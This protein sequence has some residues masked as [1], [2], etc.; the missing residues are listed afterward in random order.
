MFRELNS[1]PGIEAI[2]PEGAF[3]IFPSIRGVIGKT[4]GGRVMKDSADVAEYLL[5]EHFVATVPG[6]AFGAPENLRLS[7]AAS[8]TSLQEAVNRIRTAFS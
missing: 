6:D 2:L 4:F 5:K 8:L 1:I 7:Y 3:Y